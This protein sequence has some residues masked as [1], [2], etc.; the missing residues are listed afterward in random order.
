[1]QVNWAEPALD[2]LDGI[3]EFIARDS[4]AYA[5]IFVQ[6]IID[7]VTR[8][9][10]FP[11]SGRVVPEARHDNIR[12]VIFQGYRVVY[13]FFDEA[14]IDIIAVIHGSRDLNNPKNQPWEVN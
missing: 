9:N 14:R 13:W 10:D 8:L 11:V 4:P 12:E 7:S 3:Y 5:N 1:M 6:Q 2:D